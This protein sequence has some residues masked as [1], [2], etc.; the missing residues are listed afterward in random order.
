[1]ACRDGNH[2]RNPHAGKSG[3]RPSASPPRPVRR[4]RLRPQLA[5]ET[6]APAF[7]AGRRDYDIAGGPHVASRGTQGESTI[8]RELSVGWAPSRLQ[9]TAPGNVCRQA[10]YYAGL[11]RFGRSPEDR[12]A[13]YLLAQEHA[14]TTSY[15]Y[16][17]MWA[18][19][20]ATYGTSSCPLPASVE[21]MGCY[22]GYLF[23]QGRVTETSIRRY[24]AAIRAMHTRTG[25][26]SPTEDPVIAARRAGYTRATADRVA[27]RPSSVALPAAL[28]HLAPT[29]A[30]G[31]RRPTID[32][33][34]AVGFLSPSGPC[35]SAVSSRMTLVLRPLMR[36]FAC[37][38]GNR[39]HRRGRVLRFHLYTTPDTV[40]KLLTSLS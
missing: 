33:A 36:L 38:K 14:Q 39:G 28:G 29:R 4:R 7:H 15:G 21:P 37:E 34:I 10:G 5:G 18:R 20:L 2:P 32:A 27:S 26:P 11:I 30:I 17:Y 24:L 9:S 25:F 12:S 3:T 19:F 6:L 40:S 16:G 31:S 1:M 22:L 35:P 8:L 13:A 23:R